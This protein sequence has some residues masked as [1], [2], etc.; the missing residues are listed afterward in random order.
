MSEFPARSRQARRTQKHT[1]G[2]HIARGATRF[3]LR[4]IANSLLKTTR[5]SDVSDMQGGASFDNGASSS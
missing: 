3:G 5:S 1:P 2:A 4:L